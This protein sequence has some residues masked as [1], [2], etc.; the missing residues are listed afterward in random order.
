VPRIALAA[1]VV[2]LL[3]F[4]LGTSTLVIGLHAQSDAQTA[5]DDARTALRAAQNVAEN[6]AGYEG[7]IARQEVIELRQC[8]SLLEDQLWSQTLYA[9]GVVQPTRQLTGHC[10]A[11]LEGR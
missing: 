4:A 10:L 3:L 6:D 11:V 7:R 8:V 5:Q 1:G 2:A 9:G